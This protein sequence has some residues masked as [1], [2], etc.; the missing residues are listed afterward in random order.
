MDIVGKPWADLA[1]QVVNDQGGK[2]ETKTDKDGNYAFRNLRPGVYVIH[3][4]LPGQNQPFDD[5]V[6]VQAGTE[7]KKDFN[8][9]ELAGK[10]G[11]EY[12]ETLKKNEEAKKG[13][14]ALK[15]HVLAGDAIVGQER[16][17]RADLG[18]APAD[19]RDALKQK[20]T[21]LSNQAV[22]EFKEAQ[23]SLG[24]KDPNTP[25]VFFKLGE[26]YDSGGRNEEAAEAYKQAIALKPDVPGYYNNLGN[27]LAR[28]GKIDEAKA[29]YAKS[30]ELDPA[31][32]A[33]AYRNFGISLYNANR[34][35]DAIEPLQKATELDP[36]SAQA[37]YLLGASLLM[38]M[39]TKKVG[40][41][42]EVQLAPGTI[43]AYQKAEELDPNGPWGQQA[44]QGL[45]DLKALGAGIEKKVNVKK[46]K[47]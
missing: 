9:K 34:L 21:D 29:A 23:K 24:E 4:M 30:A 6:Q 12:Q 33:T 19:Q 3:V 39:T 37:W 13:L 1:L 17:V 42:E 38:K 44:K 36:K 31:N 35:A 7:A 28:A 45:T 27:V 18:K 14:E 22:T 16:Q 20:L 8:F 25:L 46:K 26:A 40:D 43:E 41:R 11:A 5:K 47:P 15:A 10:Q 2:Q 32:A